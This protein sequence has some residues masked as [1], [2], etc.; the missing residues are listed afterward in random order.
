MK[1]STSALFI[2]FLLSAS[3]LASQENTLELMDQ[4]P[5]GSKIL[6][7]IYLELKTA[8]ANLQTGKIHELLQVTKQN[9]AKSENRQ[10]QRLARNKSNCKKD[11]A[12]LRLHARTNSQSEFTITRHLNSNQH[13][14]RKNQQFI[15]RSTTESNSYQSLSNSLKANRNNWNTFTQSTIQGMTK[16]VR[17]LKKARQHLVKNHK[18]ALGAEFVEILPECAASLSEI[19]VEFTNTED[20]LDGLRPIISS[21]LETMSSAPLVGKNVIRARL[22]RLLRQIIKS[23][24]RRRDR[25]EQVN[26]GANAIFEALLKSFAENKLRI[27]KLLERLAHEKNLLEKR[28]SSLVDSQKRAHNITELSQKVT[29]LRRNQCR[30]I[31]TSNA[32]LHVRLQKVKNTVAQIEEI[33]QERYGV[34]KAF[35]LEKKSKKTQ[36]NNNHHE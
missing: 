18:S 4:T 32:K 13:A 35:F 33:L 30:R 14:I 19:R 9:V 10:K 24:V 27:A 11:L 3:A 20:N 17:L 22:I 23:L 29:L 6:N 21:L 15:A 2:I 1:T 31:R 7:A 36:N 28:G 26:E 16:I 25:L 12:T 5:E 34:L 8:G